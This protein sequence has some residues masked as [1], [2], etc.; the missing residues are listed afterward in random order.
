M[1]DPNRGPRAHGMDALVLGTHGRTGLARALFGSVA[2]HV[3]REAHCAVVVAP[4]AAEGRSEGRSE[5][6]LNAAQR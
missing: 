5:G 2:A 1:S 4:G 6:F 3:L